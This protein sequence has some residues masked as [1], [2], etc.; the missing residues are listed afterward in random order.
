[1]KTTFAIQ[2]VQH[3]ILTAFGIVAFAFSL[4]STVM[5]CGSYYSDTEDYVAHEWG[6]FTS[7][8]GGDGVLLDWNG[9]ATSDL[10]PF[11]YDWSR[12]GLQRF[13]F[14]SAYALK[15]GITALQRMETPVIYFYT[16]QPLNLDVAV[17]FPKGKIT[18]WYPQAAEVGP[19]SRTPGRVLAALDNVATRA[20]VNSNPTLAARLGEPPVTNSIIHWEN[21]EVL[22][23]GQNAALAKQLPT[24]AKPSHYFAARTAD[25]AFV[26][27]ASMER[28]NPAPE[29][30]KFLFYRGVGNFPTPL[31]VTMNEHG[32]ITVTNSSSEPLKH[33]FAIAIRGDRASVVPLGDLES[34]QARHTRLDNPADNRPATAAVKTLRQQMSDALVAEGLYRAEADAMVETWRDAWF[35]D[36]GVRILYILPRMWTDAT[37]PITL[38]PQPRELVRVMVGRAEVITPAMAQQVVRCVEGFQQSDPAVKQAALGEFKAMK[39]GRFAYPALRIAAVR[40]KNDSRFWEEGVRLIEAAAKPEAASAHAERQHG[41]RLSAAAAPST[42]NERPEVIRGA[43][44]D[45]T[46]LRLGQPRSTEGAALPARRLAATGG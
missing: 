32:A 34:G 4:Q 16:K 24:S 19:S 7:I 26:R 45:A 28:T 46:P 29:I 3:R 2:S 12:A 35:E 21:F 33:L 41:P 18:E 23:A 15:G 39:L 10:P 27:V 30:E 6:T 36:Q 14:S 5:A 11:V 42:A 8:Q 13:S 17:E 9:I 25:A 43:S 38:K 31:T 20:G 37:L 22:P 1:M 44:S 40:V